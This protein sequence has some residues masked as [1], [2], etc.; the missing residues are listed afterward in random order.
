M[1]IRPEIQMMNIFEREAWYE[2]KLEELEQW[3]LTCLK[4]NAD[5][6]QENK[7]LKCYAQ[8]K[9]GAIHWQLESRKKVVE[10][11]RLQTAKECIEVA[12]HQGSQFC[13]YCG[14]MLDAIKEKFGVEI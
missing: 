4:A 12:S 6:E 8:I 9:G 13:I 10:K 3:N 14:L 1:K 5:L 11:V 2:S 7:D